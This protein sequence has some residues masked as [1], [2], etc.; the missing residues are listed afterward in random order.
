MRIENR[1]GKLL[2]IAV[3]MIATIGIF[4]WL[5]V[6]A[7][8]DLPGGESGNRARALV[9]TAFQLVPNADVRRAGVKIGRVKDVTNRGSV[10]VVSFE[11]DKDQ[12]T[13][14]KNATVRIRTKTLVGENYIELDPGSPKSGP[15]GDNGV[16]PLAQAGEAV[17]LDEILSGLDDR[18]RKAIQANLDSLGGGFGERGAQL[19]RLFGT[20]P[21]T[22][23]NV[24][25]L[26]D[27][28]GD[29]KPQL[30]KMVDQTGQVLQA[31]ANRTAD[32][33]NLAVQGQRTAA[34][35]ASRDA[36]IGA[37]LAQ[38]PDTLR[39]LEETSAKLGRVS[40]RST[41]VT[42]DLRVAMAALPAVTR[43]LEES[44]NAG[45]ELFDVL[46]SV[47]R[48]ADPMLAKL[49]DFSGA[50]K[51]AVPS[52]DA[53]MRNLNPALRYLKP[54]ARDIG[55]VWANLGSATDTRDV[56]GN[57]G[58]VHALVD[59]ETI[60]ALPKQVYDAVEQLTNIGGFG[61]VHGVKRNAYP[62]PGT[63]KAPV[64]GTKAPQ[65]L[66][67]DPSALGAK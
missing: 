56:T 46:P 18:T 53:L 45:R 42:A 47:S 63:R 14:Y 16:L 7:G 1:I 55:T 11:V 33:R 35:A 52:I 44:A 38:L 66:K 19:S 49:K 20:T 50:T 26:S 29:Q 62:D 34:A 54:H 28:L 10:G 43:R 9:P 41:P 51:D 25:E 21:V 2:T 40:R 36:Q 23:K 27:L 37:T 13:L 6:K 3:F 67:T 39:Q 57:L 58:R 17:Q 31:F 8:G 24:Q 59:E 48:R 12:G 60:T 64:A 5:F 65:Q 22:L 32:V 61:H 4:G 15:L 30:A